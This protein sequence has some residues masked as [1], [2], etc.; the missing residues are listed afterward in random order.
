MIKL[1]TVLIVLLTC[2]LVTTPV[3]GAGGIQA[4]PAD[5]KYQLTR[6]EHNTNTITVWNNGNI[7]LKVEILPKRLHIW[8]NHLDYNDTGIATW[9][10]LQNTNFILNPSEHRIITFKLTIPEGLDYND[11]LGALLIHASPQIANSNIFMDLVIPLHVSVPG[12]V[13]TSITLLNHNMSKWV[14]SGMKSDIHYEIRNNGTIRT[15]ITSTTNI[16]GLTGQY[17]VT[18]NS[19]IYPTEQLNL[20]STW[21]PNLWDMGYFETNTTLSYN[22]FGEDKKITYT[23]QIIVIPWEII[24]ILIAIGYLILRRRRNI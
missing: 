9:I 20:Q 1:K 13:Y 22:N 5:F 16:K 21:H 14:F 23:D 12:P 2:I 7:P 19:M 4:S 10:Q 24:P 6:G 17:T 18:D 11:A 3:W 15:N 8:D